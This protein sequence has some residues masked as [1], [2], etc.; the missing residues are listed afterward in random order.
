VLGQVRADSFTAIGARML[1]SAESSIEEKSLFIK[2]SLHWE[3]RTIVPAQA[4]CE[5]FTLSIILLFLS[6]MFP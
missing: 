5:T 2:S 1:V 3:M 4:V 6:F